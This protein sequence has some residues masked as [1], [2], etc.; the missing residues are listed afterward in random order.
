LI[1]AIITTVCLVSAWDSSPIV[2]ESVAASADTC[3]SGGPLTDPNGEFYRPYQERTIATAA[4]AERKWLIR[5]P[6][7]YQEGDRA[8]VVFNFHGATS[9]AEN[10]FAYANFDELADRDGVILVAPDANK[11]YVDQT[12]ELA[13]Y[14][15]H[16]WEAKFRTREYDLDFVLELV[17]LIRS[18]YC[19]GEFYA[20][21][22]SAGG[23]I[24]TALQCR[25][26]NPFKAFAPVTYRYYLDDECG[27]APSYPM[28][29]FHGS[30]DRVVPFSGLDAPWFDPPVDEI[31]QSWALKNGCDAQAIEERVTSEVLRYHWDNC[32]A[33]VEW[34]LIEGGGH[35]WPGA[36][37]REPLGH[38]TEEISASELI[39][40]FFFTD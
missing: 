10:A 31:M 7:G 27:D 34:Y 19:A 12:H 26:S 25:D 8:D 21:G 4:G 3:G 9:T 18:E 1:V 15:N 29:S 2:S 39:W 13:S 22:M 14:W 35:T 20:A 17:E 24:T 36:V 37:P 33:P 16:A 6:S 30:E 5:L 40:E 32:D 11:V 28:I 38:T 23:D